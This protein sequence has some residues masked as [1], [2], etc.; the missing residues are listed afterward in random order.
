MNKETTMT[1]LEMLEIRN[2]VEN[3][4]KPLGWEF[5][6]AG[7]GLCGEPSADIEG[8]LDGRQLIITIKAKG[9]TYAVQ[10]QPG[11]PEN[12]NEANPCNP[13]VPDSSP[14]W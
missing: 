14:S 2:K 13:N 11:V 12:E 6:G 3:A 5:S 4:L 7:V 10:A 8:D 9:C 1:P